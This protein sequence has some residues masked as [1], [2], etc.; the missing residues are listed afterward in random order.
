INSFGSSV[1]AGSSAA[2][3]IEGF[4]Y[5][6]TNA[7]HQAA[8]T[9]ISQNYG[10][11]QCKRVDRITVLCMCY[12][13]CVSLTMGTLI[14]QF[15]TPLVSLY[16]PGETEVIAQAVVRLGYVAAF[17]FLCAFMDIMVGVLRGL[18]HSV[19]P[20]IVSLVGSCAFR[21]LWIATIFQVYTTPSC[22]YIS[23][24]IS[25]ALTALAHFIFF[26]AIRKRTYAQAEKLQSVI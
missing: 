11:G 20:M 6:C 1:V 15:G 19:V 7:F 12:G 22:L 9:F 14:Y 5:P 18:G 26:F 13:A 8:L 17:H 16:A 24:P 4:I 2:S 25:W 10:A 3:N 21:L 23:Y